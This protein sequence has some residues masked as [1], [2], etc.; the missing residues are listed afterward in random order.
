MHPVWRGF[1]GTDP[2][3]PDRVGTAEA[4][5]WNIASFSD[6]A[7]SKVP[8]Q[9]SQCFWESGSKSKACVPGSITFPLGNPQHPCGMEAAGSP[10][11][12]PLF[13]SP[14]SCRNKSVCALAPV[15]AEL[16]SCQEG[17]ISFPVAAREGIFRG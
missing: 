17:K 8:G 6:M 3:L 16:C 12:V 1:G 14:S 10:I 5:I 11:P 4:D 15:Q 9:L 7:S 13:H 2:A